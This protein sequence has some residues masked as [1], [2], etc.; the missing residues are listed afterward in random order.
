MPAPTD[1]LAALQSYMDPENGT[2]GYWFAKTCADLLNLSDQFSTEYGHM[3]WERIDLGEY[4][5]WALNLLWVSSGDSQSPFIPYI[6]L[7]MQTF[8]TAEEIVQ[9]VTTG[10]VELTDD[11]MIRMTESYEESEWYNDP[12]NVM[13]RHHY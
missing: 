1:Y 3:E 7:T 4:N 10:I 8:L 2:V 13:S 6:F 12:N 11:L 5:V 9:L